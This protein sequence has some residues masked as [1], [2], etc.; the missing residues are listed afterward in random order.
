[1]RALARKLDSRRD[2]RG[3]AAA[4]QR[5]ERSHKLAFAG[6]SCLKG[7]AAAATKTKA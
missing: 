1:M 5:G 7:P 2:S 6:G 3:S 4:G